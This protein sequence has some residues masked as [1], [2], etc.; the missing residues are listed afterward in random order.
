MPKPSRTIPSELYGAFLADVCRPI[1]GTPGG[2][3][4]EGRGIPAAVAER[5]GVRFCPDLS[6]L[7]KLADREVIK[8][9][10][11]SAFHVFGKAGL[12]AL[13]FPYIRQGTPVFIKTRCLLSKDEAERREVPRFLNTGGIVPC[14]WNHDA[15]AAADRVI[16]AEGE[17]D[18][19]SAI[20]AGYVGVGLPGWSHWKDA[21][22]PDFAGK[23]VF[24]VMDADEAGR[25]GTA[26]I[27]RR[28]RKAGLP[29]PRQLILTEGKDLNDILQASMKDGNQ[30]RRKS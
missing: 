27:A 2:D 13:V 1:A 11:L 30:E 5:F 18:A 6:R 19:L 10:G 22:T 23:D 17:I 15:V 3:Y 7:W 16:I 25:K 4:L 24:L 26:D 29:C 28:F 14:L 8:A 9:S 12:P 21:W 20:V